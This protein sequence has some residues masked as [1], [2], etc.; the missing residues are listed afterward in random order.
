MC[1]TI[2]AVEEK[3]KMLNC[4][5]GC[6][7]NLSCKLLHQSPR[8]LQWSKSSL[9]SVARSNKSPYNAQDE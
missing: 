8:E 9:K 6:P 5:C 2:Q 1:N 4:S 7:V 3:E